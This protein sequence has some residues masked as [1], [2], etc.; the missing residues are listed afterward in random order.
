MSMVSDISQLDPL[1]AGATSVDTEDIE[2]YNV[3]SEPFRLYGLCDAKNGDHFIGG[4]RFFCNV[5]FE[6]LFHKN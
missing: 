3:K 1:M 5:F 6:K 4:L 2:F